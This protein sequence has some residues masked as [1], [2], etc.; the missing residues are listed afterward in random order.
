MVG[1]MYEENESVEREKDS[2]GIPSVHTETQTPSLQH[3]LL[4]PFSLLHVCGVSWRH[5]GQGCMAHRCS[6]C[7][8]GSHLSRG[9]LPI[10]GTSAS[11]LPRVLLATPVP[12]PTRALSEQE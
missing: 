9:H 3:L 2:S 7:P 4:L 11:K 5:D 12:E 8:A 1:N 10:P 6:L